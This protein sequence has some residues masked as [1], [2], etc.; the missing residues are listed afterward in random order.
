[1]GADMCV[2]RIVQEFTGHLKKCL[3]TKKN[4]AETLFLLPADLLLGRHHP[5]DGAGGQGLQRGAES[6]RADHGADSGLPQR[7]GGVRAEPDQGDAGAL[8]KAV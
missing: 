7:H 8:Q 5:G 3:K 1:M 4:T 2:K 6:V